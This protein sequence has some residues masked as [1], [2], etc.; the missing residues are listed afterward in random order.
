[1]PSSSSERLVVG[2]AEYVDIPA[3]RIAG[4]RAKIDTGARSCAL[5]VE[6]LRETTD[7]LVR[8]DVRLHRSKR[9][10]RVTVTAPIARR[11]TVRSSTGESKVRIFVQ[12][13]VRIGP[14]LRRIDMGLVDRGKMIYRMLLGRTALGDDFLVDPAG[15]YLLTGR[16]ERSSPSASAPRSA[17]RRGTR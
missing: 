3:W 17:S 7:G 4:L 11:G 12:V 14:V 1:M 5:H 15:R 9:E 8:F 13:A 2:F 16:V 6:N 10:R